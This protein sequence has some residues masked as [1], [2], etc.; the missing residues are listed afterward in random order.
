VSTQ[1]GEKDML[2]VCYKSLPRARSAWRAAIF[3]VCFIL[4]GCQFSNVLPQGVY[5]YAVGVLTRDL[6]FALSLQEIGVGIDE[7]LSL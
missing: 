1:P 3:L 4:T 6:Q 5:R 7:C 2:A